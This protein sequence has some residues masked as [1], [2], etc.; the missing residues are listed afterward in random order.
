[1][2]KLKNFVVLSRERKQGAG[3]LDKY[4]AG[5][6]PFGNAENRRY[7]FPDAISIQALVEWAEDRDLRMFVVSGDK[8]FQEAYGKCQQLLPKKTLI[9]VLDHVASDDA[10]LATFVRSETMKR[11][12]AISAKAKEEFEDRYYWV[13]DQDGDAQ[14]QITKLT[15]TQEPEIIEIDKEEALLQLNFDATYSADLSY[16]DSATASYDEGTLVYVEHR[17]EEVERDQELVVEVRVAYEQVDPDSFEIIDIS[18]SDPLRW[19]SW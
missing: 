19:H 1:V 17:K 16:N 12:A 13:E 2:L 5:D 18:L 14:V 8:L 10:Q 4:F 3:Q 9:E 7:E 6:P 11:I 15:P